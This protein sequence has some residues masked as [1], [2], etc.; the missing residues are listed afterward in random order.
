MSEFLETVLPAFK[1][2]T[3]WG[4][5]LGLVESSPYRVYIGWRLSR[6]SSE[7]QVQ[8]EVTSAGLKI[9]TGPISAY[10]SPPWIGA[11]PSP[12][13]QWML[14]PSAIFLLLRRRAPA[15]KLSD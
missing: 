11:G 15:I 9:R 7:R 10:T 4:F 5:L 1:W 13:A 3:W 14:V 2:L 6:A 12:L 8:K